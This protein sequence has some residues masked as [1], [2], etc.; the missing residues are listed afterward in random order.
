MGI[1]RVLIVLGLAGLM[2]LP[3]AAAVA[4]PIEIGCRDA[5]IEVRVSGVACVGIH[6]PPLE[7]QG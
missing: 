7:R 5:D 1:R 2:M 4:E 3:M 6:Y